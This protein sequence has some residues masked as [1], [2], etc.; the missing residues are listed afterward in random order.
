M[1]GSDRSALLGLGRRLVDGALQRVGDAGGSDDRPRPRAVDVAAQPLPRRDARQRLGGGQHLHPALAAGPGRI[2]AEP[3]QQP[4]P[5]DPGLLPGD[6]LLE[7]RGDEGL[8]H[9][10]GSW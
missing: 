4:A 8:E 7:A 5:T 6:L 1:P 10:A 9:E 3:A 2:L